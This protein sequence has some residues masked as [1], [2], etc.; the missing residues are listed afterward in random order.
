M[1]EE[2]N[3]QC[4]VKTDSFPVFSKP[5]H[6]LPQNLNKEIYPV[7]LRRFAAISGW[8]CVLLTN[9][10]SRLIFHFGARVNANIQ[11]KKD[12][13][14]SQ[15]RNSFQLKQ[16][17][18]ILSH[19]RYLLHCSLFLTDKCAYCLWRRFFSGEQ[20]KSGLI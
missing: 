12:N 8:Q 20:F 14:S 11:A 13:K 2:E 18:N 7:I 4:I 16:S 10:Q 15:M 6:L 9:R 1:I 17:S 19:H 5:F 3:N